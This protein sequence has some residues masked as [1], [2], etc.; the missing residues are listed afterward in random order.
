MRSRVRVTDLSKAPVAGA[1]VEIA[2]NGAVLDSATTGLDGSVRLDVPADA[3]VEWVIA[4]KPVLGFDYAEYG[5]IDEYRR[6][7]GGAPAADVPASVALTLDGARTARIMAVDRDGKPLTGVAFT[8][9]LLHKEGRRSQVN[10]SS[11]IFAATTG[12]D[13]VATF[14]WLPPTQ[15]ALIFWPASD[16]YANRRVELKEGQSGTMTAKL[17]RTEAIRGRVVG[18]DG[19]PAPGIGVIALGS[20]KGVDNGH[21]RSRTANDGSYAM[22]VNAGEAYAVYVD[23]KDWAAPSRLDVIV[24]EGKPIDEVDFKLTRGTVIH[25]T[26]TVGPGGQPAAKQYIRL[27]ESAGQAPAEVR[28]KDDWIWH[29]VQRQFGAMTDSAG[30]YSIRVGPGTYSVIGP[31]RTG[32]EKITI[33]AEPELIRD[34]RMPRPEKGTIAG[35]VVLASEREK[36]VAGARVEIIAVI[37]TLAI[38]FAVTADANGRFQAERDLD[39]LVICAKSPDGKLGAIIE[40]GAEDPEILIAVTPTATA[41]GV[42]LDQ[43]GK[44]A[45]NQNL[46][47]GRRVFVDEK[48]DISMTCFAP[49]VVTDAKGRFTLPAL[50]VG[51]EYDISL[52]VGRQRLSNM[53]LVPSDPEK[54]GLASIWGRSGAG[55]YQPKSLADAEEMSSFEKDAPGAGK[56]APPIE[57]GEAGRAENSGNGKP[58]KLGPR[59]LRGSFCSLLDFDWATWCGPLG[60]AGEDPAQLQAVHDAFG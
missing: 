58:L 28:E 27:I 24:H 31:P 16:G 41:T 32:D 6:A 29:E 5:E 17:T 25:G 36:G 1:V 59:L 60:I 50:V 43:R 10:F 3:K 54:P 44:P 9:W 34:F 38:P 46:E 42:L 20:G 48:Q 30:R 39:P 33:H 21:G 56:A 11:R 18:P 26:V 35:R 49:K 57:G 19:S 55:T 53:S 12:A 45:A 7:K 47:W 40:V 37:G 52:H 23:D 2:G 15:E 51:Q 8:P 13:G 14:D 22:Q 4:L